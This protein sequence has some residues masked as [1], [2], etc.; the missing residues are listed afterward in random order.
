VTSVDRYRFLGRLDVEF[1]ADGEVA[2]IIAEESY[3]RR[4]I[5]ASEDAEALGYTDAVVPDE[6]L[7][8]TVQEPVSECLDAFAA[9]QLARTEILLDVSRSAARTRESGIGN[10][11]ADSFL[12]VYD[13]YAEA[14]GLPAASDENL[15]VA[16]QNGGGI[17]QN[18]GNTL[19]RNG[20]APGIITQQDTID[21]LPF[22]NFISVVENV[23]AE[24]LLAVLDGI[25][26]EGIYQ[27]GNLQI[28]YRAEGEGE[29]IVYRVVDISAVQADGA[30]VPLVRD[31][32]PVADAPNVSV[33]TNSFVADREFAALTDKTNLV[34]S[35]GGSAIL[36]EQPLR[37]Y[38]QS[39]PVEQGLPTIQA[40]DERYQNDGE[41]RI[42]FITPQEGF[43]IYLPIVGEQ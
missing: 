33:V 26:T 4:V 29:D 8:E 35:A 41:G 20:V 22:N 24:D 18:A 34:A 16:I 5:L 32:A 17:R 3:P 12:F 19:P 15:V 37:E 36:Y 10:L 13:Q 14:S 31:G 43:F 28:V 27:V 6:R 9:N 30:L 1:D 21:V 23:S 42:T 40:D 25:G 39:F 2:Q 38:L 11:V 7:I